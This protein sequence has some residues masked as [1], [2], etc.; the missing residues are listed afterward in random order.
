MQPSSVLFFPFF[1]ADFVRYVRGATVFGYIVAASSLSNLMRSFFL[2][3]SKNALKQ[4]DISGCRTIV[5]EKEWWQWVACVLILALSLFAAAGLV[6][7][8]PWV[9]EHLLKQKD[10]CLQPC[11][12]PC[13][14]VSCRVSPC[15]VMS[16][17]C[18]QQNTAAFLARVQG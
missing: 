5:I 6:L 14:V 11:V 4:V 16:L 15:F 7:A 3:A 18:W 13:H 1:F 10:S 9:Q 17:R 2:A 8:D 12:I